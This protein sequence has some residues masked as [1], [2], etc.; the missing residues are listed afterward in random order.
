MSLASLTYFDGF[1]GCFSACI[2]GTLKEVHE[3]TDVPEESSVVSETEHVTN[4][5][6]SAPLNEEEGT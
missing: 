3:D 5:L 2:Y 1:F 4:E 6:D